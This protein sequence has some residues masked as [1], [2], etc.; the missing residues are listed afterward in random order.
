MFGDSLINRN[1]RMYK[2][3]IDCEIGTFLI[4]GSLGTRFKQNFV[5][6]FK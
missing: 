1:T 6:S 2:L 4:P 5:I 3:H